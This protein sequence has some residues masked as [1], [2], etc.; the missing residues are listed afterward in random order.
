MHKLFQFIFRFRVLLL[1]IALEAVSFVLVVN[2]N[3]YQHTTFFNS[4]NT[5]VSACYEVSNSVIEFF[6]LKRTNAD[7]ATENAV[8]LNRITDL[9]NQL[10]KRRE[11]Q[12]GIIN[13]HI[14]AEKELYFIPA[15]VINISTNKIKNYITINKGLRDGV[16]PNMGV[17]CSNGVVG[18][19]KDVSERFAVVISLLNPDLKLSCKLTTNSYSGPLIWDGAD[20]RFSNLQNIAR[21]IEVATGDT[22]ITSGNSNVFPAGLPVGI[23]EE[24]ELV[25]SDMA[26]RIKVRLAVDFSALSYVDV[27]SNANMDEQQ[28]LEQKSLT[29]VPNSRQ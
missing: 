26:H 19:V 28:A 6:K 24:T 23:V 11:E 15:K 29:D 2:N 14:P 5:V 9:E 21:H 10:E 7:L 17:I 20:Y 18:I 27:V 1:F 25:E 22:V 16:R 3:R 4:A 8:L 13:P 12:L